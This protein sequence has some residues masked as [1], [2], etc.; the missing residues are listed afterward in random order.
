VGVEEEE[1][2]GGAVAEDVGVGIGREEDL[3]VADADADAG[4]VE[5]VVV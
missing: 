4:F 3:F 1:L 5:L 2:L